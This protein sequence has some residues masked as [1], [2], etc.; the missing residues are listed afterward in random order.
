M[1]PELQIPVATLRGIGAKREALLKEVG[2]ETVADLLLY[3]PAR[4]VDRSCE[5]GIANLPLEQEVTVVGEVVSAEVVRATRPRF[6]VVLWDGTG[7]VQC[8]WFS[9]YRFLGR[10][11]CPGDLVAAG[12][13][14]TRFGNQLQMVHPEVEVLS[15][16]EDEDR[17]HTGRIIPLY[18]TTARMK[19]ERMTSRGM[20][21]LIYQVL[22][23]ATQ[24]LVDPLPEAMRDR[25]GVLGLS[26]AV[27]LLHFPGSMADVEAGRKRLAFDEL[28]FLQLY[29]VGIQQARKNDSTRPLTVAGPLRQAL[30]K[31]LPFEL[32]R[33]QLHA[34]KE[35]DGDLKRP[36]V[37]H[38][39][40]QGD[41]GSGKTVVAVLAM[42][43]AL[44]AG[45]QAV[46]MAPTEIL[47]EQHAATLQTLV[48]ELG[49]DI[50]LLTG[51]LRAA[52]R[53]RVLADLESG[54][55]RLVVGTHALLQEDVRFANLG[56]VVVDEQHR[57]GVVQRSTLRGKGASPHLLVMTAT[58]IPR[59]LALT[60]Y[61]DLD[62][63]LLQELPP[64]R[65]PVRTGWR[66]AADRAKALEFVR[67]EVEK[68][69]Q[70][71]VVFPLVE[72]SLQSDL[73]AA[74]EAFEDLQAGPLQ[75]LS[76]GLLHG[77]MGG[78]DKEAVMDG[79]RKG[80]IQVL[81]ST[82]VVE[83]GVDVP[84]ATVM[85]VEHAERFGLAQL[86]Q[87]RGRVGRGVH[88]SYCILIADPK[89]GLSGVA[90]AR[91]DAISG[92]TDGF[93]IAEADLRIRGPGQIFGTRQA[94]FPEFRFAD[95]GK[96]GDLI[97]QARQEARDLLEIDP[98]LA[99]SDHTEL[100]RRVREI[101][102]EQ[103]HV[104]EAG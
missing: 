43:A 40:L 65:Q 42:M 88:A 50:H 83:V 95:L 12:G 29:L 63:T 34:Q 90:R 99:R 94:G 58:P 74:T 45:S 28:L 30:M 21:R 71:Y 37:M 72:A 61:G 59:S 13:K 16:E 56:L 20:R 47:A 62:V 67:T 19:A 22:E 97:A 86:H 68:G 24:E 6:V 8:V 75:G 64:G 18:R 57:F 100:L 93:E 91:L 66:L 1:L 52:E 10:A 2:I 55:A 31:A 101:D 80:E 76:L 49:L 78:G 44:D 54:T 14:L 103:V 25:C 27:R 11:F 51:R 84:N 82:T 39:L 23:Q 17:V 96:D 53:R 32:T 36:F 15:G 79:F 33:A 41:V 87:L 85:M 4:Y 3:L 7:K 46:L 9:G 38:R 70:A 35:I 26:Q 77:R 5:E 60:L 102:L 48:S 69:R 73:Q 98:K 89:D 92:T 81:V 104:G